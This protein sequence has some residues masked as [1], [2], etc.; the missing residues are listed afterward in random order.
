MIHCCHGN[1]DLCNFK[2]TNYHVN[3][4][5][6]SVCS[7]RLITALNC[8]VEINLCQKVQYYWNEH[9]RSRGRSGPHHEAMKVLLLIGNRISPSPSTGCVAADTERETRHGPELSWVKLCSACVKVMQSDSRHLY[10]WDNVGF[11]S[12]TLSQYLKCYYAES[13]RTSVWTFSTMDTVTSLLHDHECS[14]TSNRVN[15]NIWKWH[16]HYHIHVPGH[17]SSINHH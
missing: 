15:V 1:M 17:T 7:T 4:G 10:D 12:H 5:V 3:V 13:I 6:T 11:Y 9:L 2:A 16:R 14:P 8:T